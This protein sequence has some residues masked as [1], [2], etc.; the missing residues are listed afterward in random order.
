[1]SVD[2]TQRRTVLGGMGAAALTAVAAPTIVTKARAASHAIKISQIETLSGP[3]ASYGIR[4]SQGALMA[5][6]ELT[7]AG[8][9]TDS[10]G[11]EYSVSHTMEDMGSESR[12]AITLFRQ[13]ARDPS[14]VASV[15]PTNSVGFLPIIPVAGQLSLPLVGDGSGAPAKGWSAW[16]F[17]VNPVASTAIPVM[18]SSLKAELGFNRLGIIYDQ[19]QDAQAGDAEIANELAGELGYEVVAY[20]AFRKGDQDYSPQIAVIKNADPDAIFVASTTGDGGNIVNQIK[21]FGLDMPLFTGYGSFRDEIYWDTTDG[22]V[23]GG[24][25]WLGVDTASASGSLR[26]WIARHNE[27]FDLEANSF[28]VYG[29]DAV[30]AIVEAVRRAASP[31]RAAIQAELANFEYEAPLGT[32]ITFKNPPHGNNLTP[33]ISVI[34]VTG[35]GEYRVVS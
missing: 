9:F 3:W 29:Y 27:A 2:F 24:Y 20:E 19:S 32:R 10:E 5:I 26:D 21:A 25:T 17:R 23:N 7:E 28:S 12:Q 11:N 35:R 30:F 18:M 13:Y 14:V 31:D 8:G 22:K 4:G 6:S 33:A 15:G 16:A 34:Q 1:M